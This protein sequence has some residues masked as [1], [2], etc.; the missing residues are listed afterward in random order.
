MQIHTSPMLALA[1][2]LMATRAMTYS[3]RRRRPTTPLSAETG[4]WSC[5]RMAMMSSRSSRCRE[6]RQDDRLGDRCS[7]H[8]GGARGET[9]ERK[10]GSLSI[11]MKGSGVNTSSRAS[12]RRR[13][14]GRQVPG[15]GQLPGR[16]V[17]GA[18]RDDQGIKGRPDQAKPA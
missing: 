2:L 14:G 8:A 1:C 16:N 4:S 5:C 7:G 15:D 17:S 11:T 10:D 3:A 6:G 9:V 12:S 18:A 13:P